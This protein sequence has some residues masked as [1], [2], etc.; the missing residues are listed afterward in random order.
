MNDLFVFDPATESWQ[1]PDID[2]ATAPSPRNAHAAARLSNGQLL[3]TGGWDP[4]KKSYA[5]TFILDVAKL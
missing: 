3:V 5:D 1:W 2:Q 4:F